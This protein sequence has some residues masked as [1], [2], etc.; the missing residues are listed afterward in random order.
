MSVHCIWHN[1]RPSVPA[2]ASRNEVPKGVNGHAYY[3]ESGAFSAEAFIRHRRPGMVGEFRLG[4]PVNAQVMSADPNG[5]S[6]LGILSPV[7]TDTDPTPRQ[8]KENCKALQL[9]SEHDVVGVPE[10]CFMGHYRIGSES[11][12]RRRRAFGN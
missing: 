7:L 5:N 4:D 2:R 6:L 12:W 9:Y 1:P 10:G 3:E 8:P 11:I